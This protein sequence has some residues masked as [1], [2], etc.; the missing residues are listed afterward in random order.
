MD[1]KL[2]SQ[3]LSEIKP[4]SEEHLFLEEGVN[5]LKRKIKR[6][7]NSL[8][9]KVE[10]FIGGS[11]G[12]GTYLK[13]SSD[14]DFFV[15]FD[16]SYEDSKL[17]IMLEE[18]LKLI[19]I[20]YVR[21][22]GSRDYFSGVFSPR[23]YN[24][25]FEFVP[26]Y[27]IKKYGDARNSTDLSCF[28]VDFVKNKILND[29]NLSDEIRLSKQFFKSCKLYGAESYIN[30]FSGHVIDILICY[31][32]NLENLIL[33]VKTWGDEKYIDISSF[34]DDINSAKN[35]ME[36]D[37]ISNLIVIDPIVKNR[38]AAKALSSTNYYKFLFEISNIDKLSL[39]NFKVEKIDFDVI[40]TNSKRFSESNNLIRLVYKIDFN[41][42]NQSND[43]VGSKLRKLF[44]KI[45]NYF[46]SFDF[47]IFHSEFEISMSKNSCLFI[48]LFEKSSLPKV[49][50]ITGPKVVM[51]EAVKNFLKKREIYFVEEDRICSYETRRIIKLSEISRFNISDF[52]NLINKDVSF[53]RKIKFIR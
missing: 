37:K 52:E 8:D 24:I 17:S 42:K 27:N 46:I 26:V 12:K 9:Y 44:G 50:K 7:A 48:Y 14:V 45:E 15:R 11:F 33:D 16:L 28:H 21:Q 1:F 34:Y 25:L 19:K 32:S 41:L 20:K 36:K 23:K 49:K 18:I 40:L 38:N 10:V 3:V 31:Y 13:G 53:I 30:G 4:T 22:K 51:G 47:K 2:K 29:I 6:A 5:K 39:E 35:A 43:I